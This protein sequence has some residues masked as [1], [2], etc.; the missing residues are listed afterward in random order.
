[1]TFLTGRRLGK[2]GLLVGMG[3]PRLIQPV[4]NLQ[5]MIALPEI[6]DREFGFGNHLSPRFAMGVFLLRHFLRH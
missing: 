3:S 6:F 5:G 2:N 1:M 4:S